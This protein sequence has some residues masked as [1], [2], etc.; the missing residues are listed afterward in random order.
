MACLTF[1]SGKICGITTCVPKQQI[2]N[3]SA[4]TQFS[5]NDVNKIVRMAGVRTRHMSA[6]SI[7]ASDLCEAASKSLI[8]SIGWKRNSIDALIMVTHS[9]DYLQP[10]TACILQHK[11]GLNTECLAFDILQGCSGYPYGLMSAVSMLNGN[12]IK[13]VLLLHGD[14]ITRFTHPEDRSCAL[15]FGD[16]GSA[17]A[18]E[19]EN[20][21]NTDNWFFNL[22]TD[23]G[24]YETL[25]IKGGG[26]RNRFPD[27]NRDYYISMDGPALFN[28]TIKR[29][30]RMI[31]DTLE[32]ANKTAEQIDYIIL[33]QSNKFMMNHLLKKIG[34]HPDKA[35]FTIHK[36]GNTGG[37]SIPLTITNGISS[38]PIDRPVSLLLVGYGVG[39]SW[40]SAIIN[41]DQH[42]TLQHIEFDS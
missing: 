26:F 36:F 1:T 6:D 39:L 21:L 40:G 42:A 20:G 27:D 28:F 3:L 37:A 34:V 22:N 11:L 24:G 41:I 7:C 30:P 14:T 13:R 12:G 31:S 18:I 19:V 10:A 35:P 4:I 23:G 17:T 2:D 16:A 29:V 5:Q 15:L 33:H 38:R 9:P 8:E 25:I 32:F